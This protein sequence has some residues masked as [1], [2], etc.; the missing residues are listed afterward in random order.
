MHLN[1]NLSVVLQSYTSPC[2]EHLL[3]CID[4]LELFIST[5]SNTCWSEH[6]NKYRLLFLE[7]LDL[8]VH[9]LSLSDC[10]LVTFLSSTI[11]V[12]IGIK[13]SS[14]FVHDA[15]ILLCFIFISPYQYDVC[16]HY[17]NNY[18]LEI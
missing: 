15:C 7:T 1:N 8:T 9:S 17:L 12:F 4:A 16:I 11:L 10:N 14:I 3:I 2:I 18:K 13:V 5:K 6:L